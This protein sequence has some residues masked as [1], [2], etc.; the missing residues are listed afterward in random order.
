MAGSGTKPTPTVEDA[1]TTMAAQI[2]KPVTTVATIQANLE[3]LQGDQSR[4][5]VAINCFQSNK[6]GD[7]DSFAKASCHGKTTPQTVP[8][9]SPTPPSMDT[10]CCFSHTTTLKTHSHGS[11]DVVNFF[12]SKRLR[13]PGRCFWR[14][15]I[16][17]VTPL[18]GSPSSSVIKESHRGRSSSVSSTNDSGCHCGAIHWA[19]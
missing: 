4:L 19:N 8:M 2:E 12:A 6:I 18:S 17:P 16:C 11:T 10:S 5:T 1:L 3:T 7:G 9:P 13:T 14:H 15:F